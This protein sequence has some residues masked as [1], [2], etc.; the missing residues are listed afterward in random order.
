MGIRAK[1]K[2]IAFQRGFLLTKAA[3]S[4][5]VEGFLERFRANYVPVDLIRIGGSADGGYLVPNI[6]DRVSHCFSPGVASTSDF[7]SE[8]SKRFGIAS[9]MADASVTSPPVADQNF[10]FSPKFIGSRTSGD[11][12]TLT[13][14]MNESL[15]GTE[16]EM[17]LQMDIEGAE[18]DVLILEP[19]STLKRFAVLVIEFH[20][21]EKIF[22]RPFLQM[23]SSIF[24][25]IYEGF[26]I[27][28][29]HPN[30]CCGISKFGE[31]EVP[32][33]FEVT[34]IRTD[35]VPEF[36]VESKVALP[37]ALDARNVEYKEDIRMPEIW[38]KS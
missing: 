30:N 26:S 7:E 23:T 21:F 34:F 9:F 31:I 1:L 18:Y 12:I 33:V 3:Q 2:Q 28:H 6:L 25:K 27:C 8:L 36:R 13:D 17:I 11:F 24:E 22:E 16:R 38:W 29:V 4:S 35:L 15:D 19:Q 32:N 20:G 10:H 14:W 37:N 5:D